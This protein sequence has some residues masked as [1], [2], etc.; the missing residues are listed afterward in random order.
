LQRRDPVVAVTGLEGRDNPYPG[1]AIARALRLARGPRVTLVGLTYDPTLSGCFRDDVFDRVYQVPMP[2]DPPSTVLRRL[3]QIHEHERIDVLI[4]GLD[5]EIACYARHAGDLARAGIRTLLPPL[6]S[7]QARYKDRLEALCRE[8][9]VASPRTTVVVDPE[10]TFGV[11]VPLPCFVKGMLADAQLA[12]TRDEAIAAFWR[13][14]ARW[15]YPVLAQEVVAGDEYDVCAVAR[16][17]EV[18]SMIAIRKTAT[19]RAGKALGAVVVDEPAL[20][21]VSRL[22]TRALS[23]EGPLELEFVREASSGGFFLIEINA[24]FPAW[25]AATHAMGVNLPD[26]HLR[27]VLGEPLPE[28]LEPAPGAAFVRISRTTITTIDKL[29]VLHATGRLDH[30]RRGA[31]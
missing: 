13:I 5:S 14:A 27:L 16:G 2:G 3:L 11:H 15:G 23:W 25:C 19:S 9:G 17:G 31:G 18:L 24:R 4:P 22:L 1:T 7:V 30:A 12:R 28:R 21:A 29:G 8:N 6:A 26:L 10:R 20:L